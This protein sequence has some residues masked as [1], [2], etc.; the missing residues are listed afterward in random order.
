MGVTGEEEV[1]APPAPVLY[2]TSDTNSL[3][4]LY[5]G[6]NKYCWTNMAMGLLS[7]VVSDKVS[8]LLKSDEPEKLPPS[9]K[10]LKE[11]EKRKLAQKE[12]EKERKKKHIKEEYQREK[13]RQNIRDKYGIEKKQPTSKS[14][15]QKAAMMEE[16]KKEYG[17]DDDAR[18]LEDKMKM[19][20]SAMQL[21]RKLSRRWRCGR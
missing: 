16:L 20:L 11:E 7:K 1:R 10:E 3:I 9:E 5:T 12:A 15:K 6:N 8:G 13:V 2:A 18:E 19:L 17:L 4:Y 21:R 14:D